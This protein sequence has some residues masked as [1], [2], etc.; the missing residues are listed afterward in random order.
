MKAFEDL[1]AEMRYIIYDAV[2]KTDVVRIASKTPRNGC[3][4]VSYRLFSFSSA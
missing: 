4:F 2:A 3:M 1:P